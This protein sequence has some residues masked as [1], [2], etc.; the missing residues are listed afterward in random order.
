[1]TQHD[2]AEMTRLYGED[3]QEQ[4]SEEM[5]DSREEEM[6]LHQLGEAPL[7]KKLT[8]SLIGVIC[9]GLLAFLIYS[10]AHGYF[11]RSNMCLQSQQLLFLTETLRETYGWVCCGSTSFA[12][13]RNVAFR[14][15]GP[16]SFIS[17]MSAN[18]LVTFY[19]A[20]CGIPLFRA[21][22]GRTMQHFLEESRQHGWPSF[23]PAERVPGNVL[24][25]SS[26][27]VESA[28]G[29]HLGHDIPDSSGSRYCI[30]LICIAG[31]D[32]NATLVG[33]LGH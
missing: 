3:E 28:C 9:C 20:A 2:Q 15:S 19:D 21:P 31:H 25:K 22:I 27:E 26:G 23:R 24:V 16:G 17:V 7:D 13:P 1:M 8:R 10:Q 6:R 33:G 29:T 32:K 30:D 12:E 5:S 4:T 14:D 18:Q 11:V